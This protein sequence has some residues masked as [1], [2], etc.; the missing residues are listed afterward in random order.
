ME[1]EPAIRGDAITPW[2]D[3]KGLKIAF[4]SLKIFY[5]MYEIISN[6]FNHRQRLHV[7]P[8]LKI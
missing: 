7:S 5:G 1:R 8:L 6:G 3:Q 4:I 2:G